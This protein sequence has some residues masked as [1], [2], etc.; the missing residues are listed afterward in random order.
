MKLKIMMILFGLW[1]IILSQPVKAETDLTELVKTV[2]PTVVTVVAY[3]VDRNV[4]NIGTG[5][6]IDKNG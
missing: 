5:F 3:D 6:F 2:Q 4:A 1:V